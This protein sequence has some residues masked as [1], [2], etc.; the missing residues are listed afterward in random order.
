M[1]NEIEAQE[2]QPDL[3]KL[4]DTT[5]LFDAG[6]FESYVDAEFMTSASYN[7]ITRISLA[8]QKCQHNLNAHY[9]FLQKVV[10][11][12]PSTAGS[13]GEIESSS[14]LRKFLPKDIEI[15]VGGKIILENG[16]Y[17]PQLDLILT[18]DLPDALTGKY[19]PHEYVVAAFEVKMTLEKRYLNDI[20][21]TAALLRP[22]AREGTPREVLFGRIVYGILALSSNLQG[23][24][25]PPRQKTLE[26]NHHELK[27][28]E[29]ALNKR[30]PAH[31]SQ[32]IDLVLVADAFFLGASKTINY[33]EKYP[34]DFPDVDLSYFFNLSSGCDRETASD[35][36]RVIS[37]PPKDQHLGA[38]IYRLVLMLY[39]EGVLSWRHP[40][41]FYE[42]NSRVATSCYT[43]DIDALGEDF[44]N[45]W[46]R[47]A[48][49]DSYEWQATHPAD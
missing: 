9:E 32:T 36:A 39:T 1:T 12:D 42:F 6:L 44:K 34:N 38:F 19:I 28:L 27:A 20:A 40:Q 10:K 18:Q 33:S 5:P 15:T 41:A 22:F 2:Q 45:E 21:D 47:H 14:F 17:S 31:P 26:D 16:E 43:W 8:L 30:K 25:K 23:T 3:G 35:F 48:E 37:S 49:D 24:R 4:P 11:L 46:V 29:K 13:E 7:K